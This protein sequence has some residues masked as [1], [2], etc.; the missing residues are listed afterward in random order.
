VRVADLH[1]CEYV[2]HDAACAAALRDERVL[3]ALSSDWLAR[4][5]EPTRE[6]KTRL[7]HYK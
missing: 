6:R 5:L 7:H 4:Q 3:D 2:G 1:A